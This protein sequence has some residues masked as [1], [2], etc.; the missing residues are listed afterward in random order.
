MTA[1]TTNQIFLRPMKTAPLTKMAN[2]WSCWAFAPTWAACPWAMALVSLAVGSAPV[3]DHITI[4]LAES[5]KVQPQKTSW[6]QWPVSTAKLNW[7]S[8]RRTHNGRY[9]T[10]SLRTKV[11]GD[12]S[13]QFASANHWSAI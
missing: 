4:Q 9:S 1:M 8:A 6:C 2:G 3:M 11:Q 5:A 13:D 10:R 7:L 12:K